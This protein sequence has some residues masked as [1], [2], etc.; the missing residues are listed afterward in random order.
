MIILLLKK[1]LKKLVSILYGQNVLQNDMNTWLRFLRGRIYCFGGKNADFTIV[2]LY[3]E[4][5]W[6]GSSRN[7][8]T[9]TDPHPQ[10]VISEKNPTF[11]NVGNKGWLS[12]RNF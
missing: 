2:Y 5:G 1:Y 8:V 6:I 11:E 4:K 12:P 3:W 7:C 9:L 10:K